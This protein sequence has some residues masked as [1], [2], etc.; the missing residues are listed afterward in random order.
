M[1]IQIEQ[2]DDIRYTVD[3]HEVIKDQNGNWVAKAELSTQQ[4]ATFQKHIQAVE[5][6]NIKPKATYQL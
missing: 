1:T 4:I 6:Y 5:A 2:L 3:G